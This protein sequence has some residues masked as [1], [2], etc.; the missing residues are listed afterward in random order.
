MSSILPTTSRR[1]TPATPDRRG[2]S[3]SRLGT[4]SKMT[5]ASDPRRGVWRQRLLFAHRWLGIVIGVY[6]VIIGL[7]GSLLVFGREIDRALNPGLLT[8]ERQGGYRPLSEI[9]GAFRARY[10]DAPMTY[11]NYPV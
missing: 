5:T 10:P 11:V 6:F 4:P 2:A 8:M 9:V 1:R 7:T 3:A